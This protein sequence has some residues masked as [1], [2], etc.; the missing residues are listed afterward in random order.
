MS[1][2]QFHED[3][4]NDHLHCVKKLVKNF[5]F[6]NCSRPLKCWEA[7]AERVWPRET[8]SHRRRATVEVMPLLWRMFHGVNFQR[9]KSL[10]G[11]FLRFSY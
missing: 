6:V 4:D 1:P 9:S 7:R 10:A 5:R 3:L 8:S 11:K 2:S